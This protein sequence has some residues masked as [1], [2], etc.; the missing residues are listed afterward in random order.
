MPIPQSS[1]SSGDSRLWVSP[2]Q[3]AHREERRWPGV[4]LEVKSEHSHPSLLLTFNL[5]QKSRKQGAGKATWPLWGTPAGMRAPMP[6]FL[7][8]LCYRRAAGPEQGV[9]VPGL[10]S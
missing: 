1:A 5:W 7:S 8:A 3:E 10:T 4:F 9:G 2:L 6:R